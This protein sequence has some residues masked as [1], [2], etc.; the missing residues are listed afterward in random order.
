MGM[1][2]DIAN[3]KQQIIEELN[4]KHYFM[5][6]DSLINRI[7]SE[8]FFD[9]TQDNMSAD[10]IA[11]HEY[12]NE[13]PDEKRQQIFQEAVMERFNKSIDIGKKATYETLKALGMS[14]EEPEYGLD[15]QDAKYNWDVVDKVC[16]YSTKL[17]NKD[18]VE[19]IEKLNK[20]VNLKVFDKNKKTEA[21]LI[22]DFKNQARESAGNNSVDSFYQNATEVMESEPLDFVDIKLNTYGDRVSIESFREGFLEEEKAVHEFVEAKKKEEAATMDHFKGKLLA[23]DQTLKAGKD[24]KLDYEGAGYLAWVITLEDAR[25]RVNDNLSLQEHKIRNEEQYVNRRRFIE[26]QRNDMA[27]DPAFLAYARNLENLPEQN[28]V[29]LSKNW[30]DYKKTVEDKFASIR[31]DKSNIVEFPKNKE[32][33]DVDSIQSLCKTKLDK[34]KINDKN[35]DFTNDIQAAAEY[36]ALRLITEPGAKRI[37]F[38]KGLDWKNAEK[39]SVRTGLKANEE[40]K[41]SAADFNKAFADVRN[42]L[43][44]EDSFLCGIAKGNSMKEMYE[45]YKAE[46]RHTVEVIAAAAEVREPVKYK[47]KTK[48]QVAEQIE[49]STMMT[50]A[51][52]DLDYFKKTR[53]EL[54]TLYKSEG[55]YR[56]SYMKTLYKQLDDIIK[57]ADENVNPEGGYS[58]KSGRLAALRADGVKYFEERK[59]KVFNPIT[60]RG[61]QRLDIVEKLITKTHNMINTEPEK[62]AK[63]QER[64]Q[65]GMR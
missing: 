48:Q 22:E 29:D 14:E 51:K 58:I 11:L 56:S 46:A 59:G 26:K 43:L 61:K 23:H 19:S 40:G 37:F 54:D 62:K 1:K 25:K 9:D 63:N 41:Y 24:G 50:I 64:Q 18:T 30:K 21:K 10:D 4:S 31:K 12:L 47:G 39:V 35:L 8:H 20:F 33:L 42:S 3:A 5:R 17:L 53:D 7:K 13:I 2:E 36:F 52:K 45:Q 38:G 27:G 65:P 32:T 57:E 60:N 15:F 6:R 34:Y 28:I 44:K 55:K 49:Q 16:I